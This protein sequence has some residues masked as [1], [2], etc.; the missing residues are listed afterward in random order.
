MSLRLAWRGVAFSAGRWQERVP[1]RPGKVRAVRVDQRRS[2]CTR[3]WSGLSI[4]AQADT[5]GSLSRHSLASAFL[6]GLLGDG[7]LLSYPSVSAVLI[8]E[9]RGCEIHQEQSTRT[10]TPQLLSP[11]PPQGNAAHTHTDTHTFAA[12]MV[13]APSLAVYFI[14]VTAILI[15]IVLLFGCLAISTV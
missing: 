3:R 9:Q 13:I 4:R 2:H 10:G 1:R 7:P 5:S 8:W 15:V 6:Q 11:A 14:G 12:N